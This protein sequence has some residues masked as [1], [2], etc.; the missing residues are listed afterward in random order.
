MPLIR[1]CIRPAL[2]GAGAAAGGGLEPL[3]EGAATAACWWCPGVMP[4]V[5]SWRCFSRQ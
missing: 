2:A 1:V 3:A 5:R 4:V